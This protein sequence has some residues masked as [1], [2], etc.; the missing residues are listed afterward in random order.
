MRMRNLFFILFLLPFAVYSQQTGSTQDFDFWI[1][2]WT[3]FVTGTDRVAGQSVIESINNG[4]AIRETYTTGATEK[5]YRG[6]SLNNY[7]LL[8]GKWEQYWTDNTGYVLYM[9]GGL[10]DGAM[11]MDDVERPFD[12]SSLNRITWTAVEDGTVRQV[13]EQSTD[14]GNNWTII[15]DGTYQK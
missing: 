2:E 3:V 7:N 6:T 4:M 9:Q 11:V 14:G 13:W 12:Q 5:S 15:F 8:T 10:V 1:G